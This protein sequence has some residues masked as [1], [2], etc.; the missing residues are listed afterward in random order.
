MIAKMRASLEYRTNHT[1]DLHERSRNML[2]YTRAIFSKTKK[3]LDIALVSFRLGTQI[4]YIAYLIY[5]LFTQSPIWYLYLTLLIISAAF[6]AFDIVTANGIKSLKELGIP[7]FGSN[8]RKERLQRARKK[9]SNI[10]KI[11]FYASHILKLLVLASSLYPIISSPYSVHPIHIISVT[12]MSFLWIMQIVLE[13]LRLVIEERFDLFVEAVNAD[14]EVVTKPVNTVKNAF[15]RMI[16]KDV[17]EPVAPTKERVYL[18]RLVEEKRA[19]RAQEKSDARDERKEKISD[20]LSDRIS[21]LRG[22]AKDA[23]SEEDY[24]YDQSN[25]SAN[26]D[27]A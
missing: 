15:K 6:L 13:I 22:K 1:L 11:K 12:V 26:S 2:D 23:D 3:D 17:D 19:E 20:W 14:L 4:L 25:E 21:S 18:D 24:Y 10:R 9:R 7:F 5:M 27:E 8:E 16:G